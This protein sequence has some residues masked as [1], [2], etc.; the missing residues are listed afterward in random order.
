MAA[1][2]ARRV[3]VGPNLTLLFENRLTVRWQVQEMCRVEGITK[4]DAIAHELA[5]YNALLPR[6]NELSATLL[7]EYPDPAERA[8][9]LAALVGL[10]EH[11]WID[12]AGERSRATFDGEQ[13]NAQRISSVQFVRFPLTTRQADALADL[14]QA[15]SFVIDHPAYVVTTPIPLATRAALIEDLREAG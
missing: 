5:T 8:V 2:Q 9:K 3:G 12:V 13:F 6:A 15:A 10:H 11:V 1:T 7:V 14:R 4:P